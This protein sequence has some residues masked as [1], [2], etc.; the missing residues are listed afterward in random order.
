MSYS[1]TIAEGSISARQTEYASIAFGDGADAS[2]GEIALGGPSHHK[3][4]VGDFLV[5]KKA[6]K[7][8]IVTEEWVNHVSERL[9]YLEGL[10]ECMSRDL[11]NLRD[12]K[13]P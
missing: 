1:Y 3:L 7:P 11:M 6:Y 10:V 5:I 4:K 12:L 8:V 9:I 2:H 13:K